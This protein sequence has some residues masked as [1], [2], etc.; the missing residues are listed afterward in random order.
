M[1]FNITKLFNKHYYKNKIIYLLLMLAT[2][3][4]PYNKNYIIKN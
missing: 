4:D 2:Y 1:N 3:L